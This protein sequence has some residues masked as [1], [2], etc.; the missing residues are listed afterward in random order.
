MYPNK[1]IR[2]LPESLY[3]LSFNIDK[4]EFLKNLFLKIILLCNSLY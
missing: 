2:L 4:L 3:L 1:P